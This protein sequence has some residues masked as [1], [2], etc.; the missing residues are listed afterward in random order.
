MDEV[1]RSRNAGNAGRAEIAQKPQDEQDY[2]DHVEH[3]GMKA[4]FADW[5]LT[6]DAV[7]ATPKKLEKHAALARYLSV[8]EDI[9]LQIAARLFAGAPFPRRDERVL[10]VG[11]SALSDV[12]LERSGKSGDDMRASYQR[13]ADLGDVAHDLIVGSAH[14]GEPLTLA[15]VA[16]A[17]DG[18][19][20]VRGT[21]N[22]REVL[23]DLLARATADGARYLVKN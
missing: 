9:D 1:A 6:A 5:V 13:H 17:F 21:N 7:R 18:I 8:L 2:E 15:D 4:L 14:E 20:A 22:K 16:A 19:A 11:W 23:R 3:V 10:S 12:L